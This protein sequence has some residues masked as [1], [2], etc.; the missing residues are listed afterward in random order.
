MAVAGNQFLYCLDGGLAAPPDVGLVRA[1]GLDQAHGVEL[2][3]AEL[4]RHLAAQ[5]LGG[6]TLRLRLYPLPFVLGD[7]VVE[8]RPPVELELTVPEEAPDDG[9]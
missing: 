1:N 8:P 9:G 6:A 3:R 7:G 4:L 2:A 5:G